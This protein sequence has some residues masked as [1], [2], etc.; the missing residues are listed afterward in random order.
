MTTNHT[1]LCERLS[2]DAGDVGKNYS[3]P[4]GHRIDDAVMLI[5]QQAARI[6][7]QA[8]RIAELE[9]ERDALK[10]DAER[11]DFVIDKQGI[12][13]SQTGADGVR[14]YQLYQICEYGTGVILS[15]KALR[16]DTPRDAIDAAIQAE[17]E[18][19]S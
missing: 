11:L 15:G 14:H 4:I 19:R 7:Q 12:I 13:V 9:K 1:E 2:A 8:D 18:A 3:S 5:E 17:K 16:F 6:Q 10:V